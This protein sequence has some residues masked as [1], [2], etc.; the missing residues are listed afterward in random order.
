[1][2][3][4]FAKA[5]KKKNEIEL[6]NPINCVRLLAYRIARSMIGY[7]HH[8]VVRPSVCNA[9]HCGYTIHPEK[10]QLLLRLPIVLF[11]KTSYGIATDRFLE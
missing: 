2:L 9:V 1:M 3:K 10:V 4:T 5:L 7:L 8:S 6:Q 11:V